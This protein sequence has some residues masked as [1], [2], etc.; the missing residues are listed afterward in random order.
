MNVGINSLIIMIEI[1]K[2]WISDEAV[3]VLAADGRKGVELFSDYPRLRLASEEQR[4]NFEV[5]DFGI[6]WPDLNE[7]LCF[8]NFFQKKKANSLYLLL[9]AHPEINV[10]FLARRIGLSQMDMA[11]AITSANEPSQ[12]LMHQVI[13]S[14]KAIGRELQEV[15]I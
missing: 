8:D 14:I 15:T 11:E 4:H 3:H 9:M 13:N 10:S 7:D 2:V 5:D 12:E 1:S 6:H